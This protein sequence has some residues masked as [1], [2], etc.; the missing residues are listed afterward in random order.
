VE[1]KTEPKVKDVEHHIKRLEIVRDIRRHFNDHRRIQGAIAGAIFGTEEKKAV[2]EAG[3]FVL[4][5]SGDTIKL[6]IPADFL[7]RN[8]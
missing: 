8:W 2:I 1:I 7:P 3:L 6:D 5:Q 4:E